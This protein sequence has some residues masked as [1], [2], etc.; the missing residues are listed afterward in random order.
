MPRKKSSPEQGT[1]VAA[2]PLGAAEP[3]PE[4]K[5][6]AEKPAEKP[7]PSNGQIDLAMVRDMGERFARHA[8][9]LRQLE[10][11]VKELAAYGW[12]I[13]NPD[14]DENLVEQIT[15]MLEPVDYETAGAEIITCDGTIAAT[16]ADV[17]ELADDMLP[18]QKQG[19]WVK[20]L[21]DAPAERPR[22]VGMPD[23]NR[24]K[25]K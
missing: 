1:L 6:P 22:V 9:N 21:A 13:S 25:A 18:G 4:T 19:E 12:P 20:V 2:F 17:Q 24:K 11:D 7:A 23:K 3:K 8:E 10:I 5:A 15:A 14:F 16:I